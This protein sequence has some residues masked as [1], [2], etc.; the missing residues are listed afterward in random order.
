M[1]RSMGAGYAG[2][3]NPIFFN[4]TPLTDSPPPVCPR[5]LSQLVFGEHGEV[6]AIKEPVTEY[7][8]REDFYGRALAVNG[9]QTESIHTEVRNQARL[10]IVPENQDNLRNAAVTI[11]SFPYTAFMLLAFGKKAE[12]IGDRERTYVYEM[13]GQAE[14]QKLWPGHPNGFVRANPTHNRTHTD[15]APVIHPCAHTHM[16]CLTPRLCACRLRTHIGGA[17]EAARQ[18]RRQAQAHTAQ[19][20]LHAGDDPRR[21]ERQGRQ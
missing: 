4:G 19:H 12:W 9:G 13:V 18:A 2:A 7:T 3:E 14:I 15:A 17:G 16:R 8:M 21:R 5:P 10:Q 6:D 20:G 11:P 1:K